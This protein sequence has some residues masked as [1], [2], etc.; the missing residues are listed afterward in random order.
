MH[1]QMQ[2]V[3][4]SKETGEEAVSAVSG[5]RVY[6]TDDLDHASPEESGHILSGLSLDLVSVP[7]SLVHDMTKLDLGQRVTTATGLNTVRYYIYMIRL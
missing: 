3:H 5:R 2:P 7:Q 6:H 1:L 4:F